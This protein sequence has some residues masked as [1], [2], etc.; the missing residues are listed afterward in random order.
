MENL[1]E[2]SV[3]PHLRIIRDERG[4]NERGVRSYT[5]ALLHHGARLAGH[6]SLE[7]I[8][9][10]QTISS[11]DL[12]TAVEAA[13]KDK[14]VHG[15]LVMSPTAVSYDGIVGL[16]GP[17][18]DVDRMNP[19]T[20]ERLRVSGSQSP[21]PATPQAVREVLGQHGLWTPEPKQQPR[22]LLV[23][24]G[25]TVGSFVA[26]DLLELHGVS[27]EKQDDKL[28]I[29]TSKNSGEFEEALAWSEV[30][31]L[32][33]GVP[34]QIK[35]DMVHPG[36]LA[37]VGV[38]IGDTDRSLRDPLALAR[39]PT[40]R[41]DFLVTPEHNDRVHMGIGRGTAAIAIGNMLMSAAA[42]SDVAVDESM[43]IGAAS[44]SLN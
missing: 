25:A 32:A 27:E 19:K 9:S 37:V 41:D 35:A 4:A 44:Y 34:N 30:A 31:I 28:R 15:L 13:N 29:I 22:V 2:R 39:N 42:L 11:G 24:R 33:A 3:V 7:N 26:Q 10:V 20:R 40:I 18:K 17:D 16:I 8:V 21:S 23:G 38:C 12:V 1:V 43:L 6:V 36:L 5:A 14:T